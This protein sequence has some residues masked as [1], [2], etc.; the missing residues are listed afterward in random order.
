MN[1]LS[2]IILGKHLEEEICQDSSASSTLIHIEITE[3]IIKTHILI[4]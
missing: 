2:S 1:I 4:Q 3:D